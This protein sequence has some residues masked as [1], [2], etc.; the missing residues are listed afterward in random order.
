MMYKVYLPFNQIIFEQLGGA[1][2]LHILQNI[3]IE[4]TKSYT[5]F[6]TSND[7]YVT[8]YILYT[9]MQVFG[10]TTQEHIIMINHVFDIS[11]TVSPIFIVTVIFLT[12]IFKDKRSL[13]F[14]NAMI[15]TG[16]HFILKFIVRGII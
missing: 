5:L 4:A 3:F 14:L 15:K 7:I 1:S 16:P 12:I 11:K 8:V 2:S 10:A 13:K 9:C 6:P